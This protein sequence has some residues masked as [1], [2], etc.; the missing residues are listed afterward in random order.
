MRSGGD[1]ARQVGVEQQA[2]GAMHARLDSEV[3]GALAARDRV[4]A[5]PVDGA[6]ELYAR[7]VEVGRL[8]RRVSELRAAERSL[9]FGRIDH[10]SGEATRVGRIGIRSD[11]DAVL[12]VDWRA[13]AARP[14]YAATPAVPLGLRRRRHLRLEGRQVVGVSDEVLDGSPPGPEDVVGDDP[15]VAALDSARTGRMRE[16]AA[17]LQAEQDAIV[18]SPHRGVVVVDG[19]P[20]TGKTVVAL[21][22]AAYILYAFPAIADR[23]VLVYGPNRRFLDY[24][25]DVLPSLG[26]NGVTMA[27]LADLAG[28][29]G[30]APEPDDAAGAK[31]RADLAAGLARWVRDRQPS[32]T[33]FDVRIG[34]ETITLP[35]DLV[36]DARRHATGGGQAH[37]PAREAFKE[38]VAGHA[39]ALLEERTTEALAAMDDEVAAHLGIDLDQSVAQDLRALGLDET[40]PHEAPEIDWDAIR[41]QLVEDLGLDAAVDAIWPRLN[42]EQALRGFLGDQAALATPPGLAPDESASALRGR[43]AF[44]RSEVALLD[45]AR[46]LID[47]PPEEAYG[48]IVVDEAQELSEMEWRMLL[49]RCPARSMTVVGDFAQAGTATTIRS[50]ADALGPFV[51]DRFE[52]HRLTVNYRTTAEILDATAPLL[53]LIAPDQRLSTSIRHGDQPSTV[54]VADDELRGALRDLVE[55]AAAAWPGELIGVIGTAETVASLGTSLHDTDAVIVAAPDARGLEF[56]NVFI[57]DPEAVQTARHGGARDLYVALTR[58]TKRVWT[59]RRRTT[60]GH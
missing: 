2:V 20:G 6:D 24:I 1:T 9:C 55:R 54:T 29:A 32:W 3:A 30:V 13:E 8:T 49:R 58:A 39:V 11:S 57:V 34:T 18:R 47:G 37:N 52:H 42:P 48:H 26:E 51:G 40:I 5:E 14:F 27:T 10:G 15:L 16:A 56:D 45:E 28:V 38:L 19:G 7:D 53:A 31:G 43:G 59:L 33:A 44:T 25:S 41:D 36:A 21:H 22:R 46:A 50:W 35:A 4:L 12:L 23:G 60:G 17:T